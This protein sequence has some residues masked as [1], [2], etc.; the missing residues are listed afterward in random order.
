[1]RKTGAVIALIGICLTA[2][3][4]KVKQTQEGE[5]PEVHATGGQMPAYEVKGPTVT[6]TTVPKTVEVP[7]VNVKT[8]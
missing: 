5:M 4:C 6:A 7:K 3:A 1:M 2:S 8:P